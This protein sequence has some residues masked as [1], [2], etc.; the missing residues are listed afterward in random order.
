MNWQC[1]APAS[2]RQFEFLR[3]LWTCLE[4]ST[5]RLGANEKNQEKVKA[6][7]TSFSVLASQSVQSSFAGK[8]KIQMF[9][10]SCRSLTLPI[11]GLFNPL[12]L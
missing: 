5:K 7:Y 3:E 4:K 2:P 12:R 6:I 10:A 11:H 1:Q 9:T 8:T